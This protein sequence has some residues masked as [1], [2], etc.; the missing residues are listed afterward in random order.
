MLWHGSR[1]VNKIYCISSIFNRKH[2]SLNILQHFSLTFTEF[3]Q[4]FSIPTNEN[5]RIKNI[6]SKLKRFD[7]FKIEGRGKFKMAE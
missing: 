2:I 6:H 7:S 3:S 4:V 1:H 5:G